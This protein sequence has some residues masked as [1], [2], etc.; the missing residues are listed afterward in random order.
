MFAQGPA[1]ETADASDKDDF[2]LGQDDSDADS[3]ADDPP[4]NDPKSP[5]PSHTR[6]AAQDPQSAPK[7]APGISSKQAL[8]TLPRGLSPTL[9]ATKGVQQ[10]T[11][12][13]P[14]ASNT[15]TATAAPSALGKALKVSKSATPA[16]AVSN[17]VQQPPGKL[18]K[19][20]NAATPI[21]AA[22]GLGKRKAAPDASASVPETDALAATA[23]PAQGKKKSRKDG[24]APSRVRTAAQ[25]LER[26]PPS[27]ASP[28]VAVNSALASL[29]LKGG[30]LPIKDDRTPSKGRDGGAPTLPAGAAGRKEVAASG[31]R[32]KDADFERLLVKSGGVSRVEFNP[33]VEGSDDNEDEV[34]ESSDDYDDDESRGDEPVDHHGR[35]DVP[36]AHAGRGVDA[37]PAPTASGRQIAPLAP[38]GRRTPSDEE[39]KAIS[40]DDKDHGFSSDDEDDKA[41]GISND[42]REDEGFSSD[43]DEEEDE[44]SSDDDGEAEEGSSDDDSDG[45]VRARQGG[46]PRRTP[47]GVGAHAGNPASAGTDA[48]A[49]Y[50][51]RESGSGSDGDNSFEGDDADA[52]PQVER[53]KEFPYGKGPISSLLGPMPKASASVAPTPARRHGGQH[54]E[55]SPRGP[56]AAGSHARAGTLQS[57]GDPLTTDFRG[58]AGGGNASGQG[59]PGAPQAAEK[60]RA[61]VPRAVSG[62]P[63]SG[64]RERLDPGKA[65]LRT[66][67]R[68]GDK[69]PRPAVPAPNVPA[70]HRGL[71]ASPRN[72]PLDAG[73]R[74]RKLPPGGGNTKNGA[75]DFAAL[76]GKFGK[77]GSANAAGRT[78][79]AATMPPKAFALGKMGR[80]AGLVER[81]SGGRVT[82][83]AAVGQG[84]GE[85]GALRVGGEVGGGGGGGAEGV[86][87]AKKGPVKAGRKGEKMPLRSRA[88]GGRKRRKK[89]N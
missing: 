60:P 48:G 28:D 13:V 80:A 85:A 56:L 36:G 27:S 15:A 59:G 34:D 71:A 73:D 4:S 49:Q 41:E 22:S 8:P 51:H 33:A 65:R 68:P 77:L 62:Q 43:A 39:D 38:L 61:G 30:V 40:N 82:G 64:S 23:N 1:P 12:K 18:P 20:S 53:I 14:K 7:Q 9:P 5:H 66:P 57:A 46:A 63:P 89:R 25:E 87:G 21:A 11:G 72:E 84:E 54:A 19:V 35:G 17:G 67:A 52:G 10:P 76:K 83:A 69:R 74:R 45:G 42:D 55:Q 58:R 81:P 78:D 31:S 47:G 88:E 75:R 6:K 32:G 70:Q 79:K 29:A 86:G 44:G 50:E 16:P 24:G 2:F 26:R 37:G 3:L